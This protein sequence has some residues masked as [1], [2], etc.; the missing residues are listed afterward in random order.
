M[1]PILLNAWK[2]FTRNKGFFYI[3]TFQPV[4]VFLL[5]SFLLPYSTLHNVALICEDNIQYEEARVALE[6]LGGLKLID[7]ELDEVNTKLAMGNIE[8]A[9]II[10]GDKVSVRSFGNSEVEG[11]V[12]LCVEQT[13]GEQG[14]EDIV[15]VNSTSK[16]GLNLTNSLGFMIYK[17]LTAGSVLGSMII[18]ER[19]NRMKER[20]VLS[21]TSMTNYLG[22]LSLVYLFF[23]MISTVVYYITALVLRFDFGMRNSLGFLFMIFLANILS[24]AL[25][26]LA[27]VF[28][29]K[30]EALWFLAVF[31]LTPMGLFSGVLFPYEF[32]PATMQKIGS[33]F[34]QRWISHGIEVMQE[35]GS[36]MAALPNMLLIL[37]TS[38]ILF[39]CAVWQSKRIVSQ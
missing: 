35:S 32:M 19:K 39:T 12:T 38:V 28:F 27:A 29:N 36:I 34:P 9:V 14:D 37:G 6:S 30:E 26:L 24:T 21:G 8:L 10:Q 23:M 25:F 17:T 11:I 20:I 22:G 31:V 16:K 13:L 7:V 1:K 5:M 4:F 2:L 15:L 18:L 3:L 33:F